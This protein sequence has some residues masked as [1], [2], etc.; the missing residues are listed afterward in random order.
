MPDPTRKDHKGG[1]RKEWDVRLTVPTNR[2]TL[3]RLDKAIGPGET[4]LDLIRSGIERE[5][6]A[7]EAPTPAAGL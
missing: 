7:R 4:R 5:L 6:Q 3:S 2:D 1:R